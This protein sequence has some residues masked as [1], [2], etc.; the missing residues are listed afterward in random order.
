MTL[1]QIPD[2]QAAALQAKAAAEG[3]TL[4]GWLRKQAGTDEPAIRRKRYDLAALISEC[5]VNAP[6]SEEDTAWLNAPS[7]GREADE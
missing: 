2:D 4:E 5:D 7:I 1:L 6:L 3:L